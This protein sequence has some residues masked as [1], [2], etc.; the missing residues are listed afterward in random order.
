MISMAGEGAKRGLAVGEGR[1]AGWMGGGGTDFIEC[2]NASQM[3]EA[4]DGEAA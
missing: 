2:R 1:D 4:C 3:P